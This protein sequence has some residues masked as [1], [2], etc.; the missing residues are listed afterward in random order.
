MKYIYSLLALLILISCAEKEEVAKSWQLSKTIPIT[1]VNAIGMAITSE[2]IWLSD[3]D[4]NRL[5]LINDEG[6]TI[7]TID[8][9]DRP[10]HIDAEGEMLYVPQYGND[11]VSV[12]VDGEKKTLVLLDSLDAPAGVSTYFKEKAIADFYNNRIL[13]ST[14]GKEFISFGKEGKATG[15]FYYPTDVQITESHIWVAD[16]YN[17][18]IQVFDKKGTFLKVIGVDQKMN[19]A[20][21][22]FV[23]PTEVFVTDFENDRVLIFN[24]EGVLQQELSKGVEKPIEV[25]QHQGHLFVSNYRR[26]ELL[27]FDWK[28]IPEG[29]NHQEDTHDHDHDH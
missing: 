24:H 23:N 29:E 8:S 27:V 5:V 3:G 12:F 18:R 25:I 11:E 9:L 2:G 20:T 15:D 13:Y 22:I 4:H 6:K 10:M 7:K 19:A 21:G 14:D 16:A 26:S 1:G 17:N 28:A